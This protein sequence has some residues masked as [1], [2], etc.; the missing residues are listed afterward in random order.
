MPNPI[1]NPEL[2]EVFVA[3]GAPAPGLAEVTG[4]GTPRGWDERKGM[5]L[6]GATLAQVGDGLPKFTVYH[7]LW[8]PEHITVWDTWKLRIARGA[9]GTRYQPLDIYFPDLDELGITR[10]VVVDWKQRENVGE[11]GLFRYPVEWQEYRKPLPVYNVPA[12]SSATGQPA[13]GDPLDDD[14]KKLVKQVQD[15]S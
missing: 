10:A 12:G 5:G 7:Y 15:L 3:G 6:S 2:Y 9:R 4:A 14:I 13:K 1:D 11:L 8:L